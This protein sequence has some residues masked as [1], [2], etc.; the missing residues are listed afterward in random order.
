[1]RKS[2]KRWGRRVLWL[3]G[4]SLL[5]F[6]VWLFSYSFIDIQ[7]AQLPLQFSL[8]QGS[9]LR[10]AV[11]QMQAA[12]ALDSPWQFELLAR[13]RGDASR[14]QA[15]SYE[16]SAAITPFALLRKITSGDH[17]QVR[18]VFIEG[19]TFRQIRAELDA[20][21]AIR[22]DTRN[23]SESE[24]LVQL[25]IA[26]PTTEGLFFPD[27]YYFAG[28]TSDIAV[29]QRTYRTMQAQ[30]DT[31]WN[32]RAS[33]L[34]LETPYQ[35]LILASIVEK[36]TGQPSERPLIAAVFINR[37]K[38][39]MRLQTDPTV[40]YGLGGAFDGNLRKLHLL[41]DGPYNTYMREGLPPTP[42]SMPGLGALGAT[43]NPAQNDALYFVAR[44]DG[45]SHFSRTLAEHER[46]VTKYQR[47]G[48][49]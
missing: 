9:S 19:W 24:I 8:Q 3:T 22:H 33:G 46:A 49:R 35:A 12:G 36:E 45:T 1:M 30:L 28:G 40:I 48:N 43:L 18:I 23:L 10:S 2:V 31:L 4:V 25:G 38:L 42:I 14:I 26:L 34:P 21:N 6:T 5:A 37:L 44:G 15:G 17:T 39:G 16:L 13:L 7:I 20:H 29:L 41:T 32:A 27:T 11:R 47:R